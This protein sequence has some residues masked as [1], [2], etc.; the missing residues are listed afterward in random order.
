[1]MEPVNIELNENNVTYIIDGGFLLHGVV[2]NKNDTSSDTLDRYV[3]YLQRH[4]GSNINVI[5]DGYSD[6]SKKKIKAMEQLRR[7]ALSTSYEV[8]FDATMIVPVTQEKFLS[9]RLLNNYKLPA[10]LQNKPR[11]YRKKKEPLSSLEKTLIC[12]FS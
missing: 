6:N 4:F 8:R 12:L 11:K 5:F 7:S 9:N 1:M 2:G 10:S 3:T